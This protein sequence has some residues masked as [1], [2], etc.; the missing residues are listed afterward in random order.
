MCGADGYEG[1]A[2][3][4]SWRILADLIAE[5]GPT[6][7]RL[8]TPGMGD[9]LDGPPGSDRIAATADALRQAAQ[10]LIE[11]TGIPLVSLVALRAGA[12]LS[13]RAFVDT[14]SFD[15]L[16]LLAPVARGKAY[17]REMKAA[18]HL[19]ASQ[20]G[21]ESECP[22]NAI[23]LCG[24]VV[25]ADEIAS[26]SAMHIMP[27]PKARHLLL[28]E[29]P[30]HAPLDTMDGAE[31]WAFDGYATMMAA[32]EAIPPMTLLTGVAD[33]LAQGTGPA[34]SRET[35]TFPSHLSGAGFTEERLRFSEHEALAGVLTQPDTGQATS[36]VI[37]A[38]AGSNAHIGWARMSVDHARA[39]ARAGIASLRFD[40]TGIGDAVWFPASA[41]KAI[42]HP[43]HLDDMRQAVDA[44]VARG[45]TRVITAG[46]CS[47]G[48]LALHAAWQDHRINGVVA[49]N[50]LKLIWGPEDD[51]DAYERMAFQ[52]T[53]TYSEKAL[54]AHAWKR[55]LSGDISP[56]RVWSVA[57]MLVG[58][59]LGR[60]A[61]LIGGHMH[62][63]E[64]ADTARGMVRD[65]AARGASISFVYTA[66][67]ASRDEAERMF[68]SNLSYLSQFRC[69]DVDILPASDHE[70]TQQKA[71]DGLLDVIIRRART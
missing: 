67:D 63:P 12:L 30:E 53:R 32:H 8:D 5:R 60:I 45:F 40:L 41:R 26:L 18:A 57:T 42:Y 13:A 27:L 10:W 28:V 34:Q 6:V 51:L 48:Y 7:L 54:S 1:L 3:Y 36:C 65:I 61:S 33:W 9:S 15:R 17:V 14:V 22:A 37:L 24:F 64:G 19:F 55:L 66:T 38:N 58:K 31:R 39:L 52:S 50:V 62:L 21:R 56:A 4:Q 69:C 35:P 25:S 16:A 20:P 47:G 49:A 23:D 71:R 11:A 43:R 46:L 59:P 70:M 2:T 44:A 68:G 29:P